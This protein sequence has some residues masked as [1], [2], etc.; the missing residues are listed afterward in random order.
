MK[1]YMKK[2]VMAMAVCAM[3]V[4]AFA[5]EPV[6]DREEATFWAQQKQA[7]AWEEAHG[8]YN[9][10]RENPVYFVHLRL[11]IPRKKL[12]SGRSRR[13]RLLGKKP[14]GI[15]TSPVKIRFTLSLRRLLIVPK[16]NMIFIIN[17]GF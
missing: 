17:K 13:N 10:T 1:K 4:T 12:H 7:A 16:K 11:T 3:S 2:M 8:N 15:T 6:F 5:A 9:I 14:T